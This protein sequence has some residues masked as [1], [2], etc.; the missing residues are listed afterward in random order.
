MLRIRLHI[1]CLSATLILLCG[2][3]AGRAQTL[4]DTLQF[5]V[6]TL[7]A[8]PLTVSPPFTQS[9]VDT[10]LLQDPVNLTLDQVLAATS[11]VFIRSY[12]Q[13]ALASASFRGT[14]AAHTQVFWNG[15]PVNSTV[16]GQS[17]LALVPLDWADDIRILHGPA[18]LITGNGGLGGSIQLRTAP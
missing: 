13:G 12:G 2:M 9:A 4:P 18:S 6:F 15:L 8:S 11:P 10:A 1:A 3:R 17:D 16:L 5:D 7:R 14:G